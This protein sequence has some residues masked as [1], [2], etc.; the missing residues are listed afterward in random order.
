MLAS[1]SVSNVSPTMGKW[2]CYEWHITPNALDDY[3]DGT[4][5]PI[6]QTWAEPT[7]SLLRMGFERFSAGSAGELWLDDVAINDTQIGCN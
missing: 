5:L 4:K 3:L 2:Q 7:I 6:S 1:G